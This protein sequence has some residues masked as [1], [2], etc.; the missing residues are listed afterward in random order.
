MSNLNV[1]KSWVYKNVLIWKMSNGQ[2]MIEGDKTK[3]NY[4]TLAEAKRNIGNSI[5][6]R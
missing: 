2:H 4:K 5:W 3:G 1:V 6:A